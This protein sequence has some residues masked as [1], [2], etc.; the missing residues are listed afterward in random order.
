MTGF[1]NLVIE[2][3]D[4]G[5]D[6][7]VFRC[8]V[9]ALDDY[10]RKQARQDVKRHISRVYVA[11]EERHPSIILG[12]YTL[13]TLAIDFSDLP[14]ALAHKLPRHPLPAALIGR[15][16]VSQDAQ[17]NGVGKMLLIN[18]LK[19]TLAVSG[20]IAIYAMV[21]DAIDEC[22]QCFYEK[23]GFIQLSSGRGR[24]F[25]PLKSI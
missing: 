23:F 22:A 8:G 13:S 20:E 6:R 3:L 4:V 25:L 19:R 1:S 10:I 2:P 7:T 14:Q 11:I 24:L 15:L 17:G 5:H 12:Y 16:A 21:V 9:V 18:A